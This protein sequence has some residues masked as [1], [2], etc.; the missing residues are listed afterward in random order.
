MDTVG[1]LSGELFRLSNIIYLDIVVGV[2][3]A[4]GCG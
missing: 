2:A 3:E 4:G 1:Q